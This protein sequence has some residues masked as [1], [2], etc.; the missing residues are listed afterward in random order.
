MKYVFIIILFITIDITHLYSK[1]LNDSLKIDS[2]TIKIIQSL[3]VDRIILV[4]N[5][6]TKDEVILRELQTKEGEKFN[7]EYLENDVKRLY[8]LGLFNRVDVLPAPISSTKINL[9]FE[10]E[11][12]FYF[13]PIPQGGIKEGELKKI[14]GG[15]NFLWKNFRG[16]NETL[17][18]SF[19]IGYEPFISASYFNPWLFGK[20]HYFFN[21]NVKYSRTYPRSYGSSDSTSVIFDKNDVP[22]YK[23]DD[24][25][26]NMRIG[27]FLGKNTSVSSILQINLLSTSEYQPG[28]T[29]SET[30]K[31]FVPSFAIDFTYDT[32][33]YIK[34][35]TFGSYYY[36]NLYRYGIFK[37]EIDINKFKGDFRK[38][39]PVNL[40]KDYVIILA[41]RFNSVLTFGG[42]FVPVY[43][44]ES[45]GYDN[46]IRGWDNY[47]LLG[48]DKL[49]TSF[50]VRIPLVKPFYVK[51]SDHFIIKKLPIAKS[52]S[53][54]YG[55]YLTLFFDLGG[56][57]NKKESIYD[58]QFRNG[59]GTG[60]NFLLPFDFVG[61]VDLAFRKIPGQNNI[62]GQIIFA[63][64]SSF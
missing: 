5:D 14:W 38:F 16:M 22:T 11:E 29:I 50:E 30:G 46:L 57:W 56:V 55:S 33:D 47:V 7:L 59:F 49:Y 19:G 25:Q 41:S 52:F 35:P 36:L 31:D 4:G 53:Y 44:Q 45:M 2:T 60:L 51:G 15:V 37:K 13:L 32:R 42:G 10:F 27:K 48:D 6:K 24:F 58:V 8:N 34:F 12:V 54:R 26:A 64:D 21:T 62:K 20:K 1:E 3:I 23:M 28:R 9:V 43:L 18:L 39:I 40:S 63:L 61:R 17:G